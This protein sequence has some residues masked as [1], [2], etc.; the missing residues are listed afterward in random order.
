MEIG[1]AFDLAIMCAYDAKFRDGELGVYTVN[2]TLIFDQREKL[3][4]AAWMTVVTTF[5]G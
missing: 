2:G 1:T 3:T 4:I 5:C